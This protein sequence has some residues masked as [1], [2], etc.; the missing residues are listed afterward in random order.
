MKE[1][2]YID[3]FAEIAF[4]EHPSSK[5]GLKEIPPVALEPNYFL[6]GSQRAELA[7]ALSYEQEVERFQ[8]Q[9]KQLREQYKPF[10]Q[11]LAAPV[12][13]TRSKQSIDSFQ[14]RYH[15]EADNDFARV[16]GGAGE[17]ENVTIPDF[18]GP[19]GDEG[20]W[21][22]YYR[23][24]FSCQKP[25]AGKRIFLVF[26]GVDYK[27][28]VYV[29]GKCVGSHEGFFAPFEFDITDIVRELNTLVVQ[30]S[31]DYVMNGSPLNGDKIYAATGPGWDDPNS[32]W[33]HC[34]SGAGIYNQ[35]YIEERSTMFIQDIFIRP[36]MDE[37]AVEA[38]IDVFNTTDGLIENFEI[39]LELLPKNFE[40]QGVGPISFSVAYAGPGLNYYRYKAAMPEDFKTWESEAPY[41]YI[42]R[43]RVNN[44]GKL[45]DERDRHFGM[46]KFHMDEEGTP[47]GTIYFNNRPFFLRGA[48]EMGH[49]QQC[50]MTNNYDQLVDDIL[51]AKI[52]NLNFYRVTQRPVQEEIYDYF[53]MLGMMHQ[54][55]L[56]TFGFIRR[57]QFCE[58][59]R[60]AAEMER[61]IRS[62]PSSVMVSLINEPSLTQKRNRGHRF[63]Y[64]DE[65]EAF[66]VACRQ[67]IYIEN[68]DRVVKN[69]DGDYDPPTREGFPDFHC[70]NMWYAGNILSIGKMYKGYLPAMKQGWKAG[71][72]EYGTEGLDNYDVMMTRYPKEWLPASDDEPWTPD[73]IKSAQTFTYHGDWFAEQTTIRE[74][75]AASQKH[76][77]LATKLMTDS[78]RRRGDMVV[79]TAIHLLIDAWP[80]GWMKALVGVD[81]VPK[82]AYFTY[83][84]CM[85]PV[86][87][88]LRSDRWRG[89]GGETMEIE[90]W[91]MN[92]T[93]ELYP[94]ARVVATLRD[95]SKEYSSFTAR[96]NVPKATAAYGGTIRFAVPQVTGRQTLYMDASL[97][98]E[99]GNVLN[100]ERFTF[101]AFERTAAGYHAVSYGEEAEVIR[102]VLSLQAGDSKDS[103]IIVS[104]KE[105]YDANRDS[106]LKAVQEGASALV[107]MNKLDEGAYDIGG[108]E[109]QLTKS[110]ETYVLAAQSDDPR[111]AW[112]KPEDFTYFYN[113][114]TDRLDGISRN[115]I[116][117]E[118]IEP[119]VF[120]YVKPAGSKTK[121]K[122]PVVGRKVYGEGELYF[123]SLQLAGRI[124]VNPTLDQLLV[125]ILD[126][127]G[128]A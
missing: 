124:G 25:A 65:L 30:V 80:S 104:S 122:L 21:T 102:S 58:G 18:K 89:Y 73:T 53:D 96:V 82:P 94:N 123:T 24:Q 62:H 128:R 125:S 26:K 117:G 119:V 106:I 45:L 27:A 105:Q 115:W 19:T 103:A 35:V 63:L 76:Q 50:V 55:D 118:G 110:K 37:G 86:R 20:R 9:L 84:D 83:R 23:Q 108:E 17:W 3:A 44:E 97:I 31:N 69:T 114:L 98:D 11:N 12:T 29:N 1:E 66:F 126:K 85:V 78:W 121:Q 77:A 70:Y 43:A 33:H 101:E 14:F 42:A 107:L 113:L 47:K 36:N 64:R 46:R 10:M 72:G 38:W 7:T 54:T 92:D 34:P 57:N 116:K 109:V 74:W 93:A 75:I 95:D 88:N 52:A 60:Q 71:C 51:I 41:L 61:L 22:G 90:A 67:A 81:R 6:P 15:E 5:D 16:L 32:G 39:Q 112:V 13:E 48:N 111:L 40:G 28:S 87:V 2:K 100:S 4:R 91:L 79:S 8:E 127:K 59:V 99:Q 68:P 56:P 120:T 49:L